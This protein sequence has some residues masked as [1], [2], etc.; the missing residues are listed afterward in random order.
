V[1]DPAAGTVGVVAELDNRDQKLPAG[2]R[3]RL[4]F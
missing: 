2:I 4:R 1:I 3:C